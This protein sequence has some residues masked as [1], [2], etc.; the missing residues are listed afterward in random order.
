MKQ[1]I[2][3]RLC[4]VILTAMLF[5]LFINYYVQTL[6]ARNDMYHDAQDK[7]WQVG[8]I[9]DQNGKEAEKEKENLKER[10]FIRAKAIAY[11]IKD[12]PEVE[13]NQEEIAKITGLL[14]V[15]EV[16]LFDTEGNLYAGSEPKYFG[17]NFSSGEQMKFFLPML[18]DYSLQMCQD[19]TPNTAEGKLMQY[20]A[21]WREDHKG[22]VQ[23]GLEP[24]TVLESL[25]KTEL[26]YVFSLVTSEK[27]STIYAIDPES[28]LILGSTDD[29]L[30]G[31]QVQDIG[32][33]PDQLGITDEVERMTVNREECYGVFAQRQSVI[34]G[35][36]MSEAALYQKVNRSTWLVALYL[37][38]ISLIMIAFISNY[39]DRYVVE[40]ISSIHDKLARITKGNLDTRVAV[41]STPEFGQ[42]SSQIN[43]MVESLLDTTNK[44]SHILEMTK[45]PMGVYEYNRDMKR[46]MAT[47]R[48]AEILM[49]GQEDAGML[50]S[51][52]ILFEKKLEQIRRHPLDQESGVYELQGN[53][54]RFIR[55]EAF[56]R[57]H[58][59]LGMIVD[60]TDDI[61]EKRKIK[62]ERD[63][64]LLTG[65]YSRRAFYREL[66]RLFDKPQTLGHAMMLMADA[67]KLK[68]VNDR[69]G[70]E[71]GDRY[72]A[73]IADILKSCSWDKVIAARLSGDEFAL[74]L[75]GA[76]SREGL[77]ECVDRMLGAMRES[78]MELDGHIFIPVRFS[79]GYTFYPEEGTDTAVLLRKADEA[80]YEAKKR[81]AA[82]GGRGEG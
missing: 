55:I 80:M 10:C 14:Q 17:L 31:R 27:D 78:Q 29:D 47:S 48:L 22:I 57:G 28:L 64:D 32:I 2:R 15:D 21:I 20:A 35:I 36:T 65:L 33:R 16:H 71:N 72:L 46:V 76:T 24:T 51:D 1:M 58:S 49:L 19:I 45:I 63:V 70:H 44:I 61:L 41:D 50:L 42:L 7:F 68:Q 11:I 12:R 79:A 74:F 25:E 37:T 26:S 23:V 5:S 40:G 38:G 9:L 30:V 59:T 60:V 67:D 18:E 75:Y 77:A 81:R 3:R 13:G 54:T 39:I 6:N 62:Q 8:Q 43:Q 52:H 34:L 56:E 73:S 4:V 69:Y 53:A 66:E 82:D